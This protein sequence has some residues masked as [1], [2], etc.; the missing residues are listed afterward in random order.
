MNPARNAPP[1]NGWIE[2][3]IQFAN[4][5]GEFVSIFLAECCEQG[6]LGSVEQEET[7]GPGG[8]LEP[9]CEACARFAEARIFFAPL[10]DPE[11]IINLIEKTQRT[12]QAAF[13]DSAARLLELRRVPD[14][15]WALD[16][17]G[18]FPPLRVSTW[19]WVVPPWE[20]PK[21]APE[22]IQIVLEPGM[23]FGTGRHATTR[24]CLE[25]LEELLLG[26]TAQPRPKS[27]LDAGCGSGILSL[28]AAALGARSVTALDKDPEAV[29]VCLRN[30]SLNPALAGF[31]SVAVGT[32]ACLRGSSDLVIANLDAPTL[33]NEASA[34]S[35][36]VHWRGRLVISGF[37]AKD[38][39]QVA[40][41]FEKEGF[42]ILSQKRD[43]E[44][45]WIALLLSRQEPGCDG[46]KG[47]GQP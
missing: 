30:L 43:P 40:S 1:E 21:P 17:K 37:L 38:E 34:I 46:Q 16:S 8:R 26:P 15:N 36:L 32:P 19:I 3:R 12:L 22:E 35:P 47:M 41:R 25:F 10:Q 9:P 44:E 24:Q 6:G 5:T 4:P 31:V 14:R 42:R 2:A 28:A 39:G 13:P 20:R 11:D 33:L 45:D 29:R 27:V 23:A 7:V 18:S